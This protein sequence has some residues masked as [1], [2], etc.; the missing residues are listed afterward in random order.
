MGY[1]MRKSA[2]L[3]SSFRSEVSSLLLHASSPF[4]FKFRFKF[5]VKE[6]CV[7]CG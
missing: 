4:P 6:I 1:M 3:L 2:E 5:K 7:I